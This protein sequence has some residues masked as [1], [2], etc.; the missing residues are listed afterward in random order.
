VKG[1]EGKE[2]NEMKRTGGNEVKWREE[3]EAKAGEGK[4]SQGREEKGRK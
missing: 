4:E 2:V 3:R 1:R